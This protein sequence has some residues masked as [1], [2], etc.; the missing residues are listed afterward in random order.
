[1]PN[2]ATIVTTYH[3]YLC[4]K[5]LLLLLLVAVA[6]RSDGKGMALVAVADGR[7]LVTAVACKSGQ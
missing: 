2:T 1:M 6:G 4:Q 3:L 5:V 7:K